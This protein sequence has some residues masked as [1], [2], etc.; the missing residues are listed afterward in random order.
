MVAALALLSVLTLLG[1]TAALLTRTDTKISGNFR[2]TQAALQVAMGGVERAKEL[3]RQENASSSDPASFSDELANSTRR[4]ANTTLDGHI[5]TTDDQP[6]VSGT[7]SLVSYNA[8]LTNDSV[9]GTSNIADSNGRAMITS[10]A[11][12]P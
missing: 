1:T 8:Y 2:S 5:P 11:T 10:V 12:G 3:L 4:G 6:L 7:L 9:D